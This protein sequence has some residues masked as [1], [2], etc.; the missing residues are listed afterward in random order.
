MAKDTSRSRRTPLIE[1][2]ALSVRELPLWVWVLLANAAVGLILA[3]VYGFWL[4]M[5][6]PSATPALDLDPR[7]FLPRTWLWW[8]VLLSVLA[9]TFRWTRLR[10][11]FRENPSFIGLV[12][13]FLLACIFSPYSGSG[14][15]FAQP[16]NL[17]NIL[18]QVTEIGILAVGMTL[19]IV[20]A[21]IDLSVGSVLAVSATLSARLLIWESW[22]LAPTVA[23]CLL[24]G[25]ALGSANGLIIHFGRIQPFVVTLATMLAARGVARLVSDNR[26]I[27]FP[28]ITDPESAVGRLSRLNAEMFRIGGAGPKYAVL[29]FFGIAVAGY[30]LLRFTSL[31]RYLYAIGSNE[32]SAVLSGVRVGKV[33]WFAYAFCG[34]AAALAGLVH[35][36]QTGSGAPGD[37]VGFELSAIAAVVIGGTSLMGGIGTMAGTVA[38]ALIIGI[39]DNFMGI[40]MMN[41][42]LQMVLKGLIIIVAVLLQRRRV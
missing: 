17:F 2:R 39:I 25:I 9:V 13:I 10:Q 40:H 12:F 31:G 11:V 33:K 14:N 36:A 35:A 8:L 38:G 3:M 27:P 26:I 19:V 28:F 37:A 30:G 16:G 5:Q 24:A 21:G 1:S 34:F 42:N 18:R 20:S 6:D 29:V 15:I 22:P 7:V 41:S 32:R 23:V 4:K